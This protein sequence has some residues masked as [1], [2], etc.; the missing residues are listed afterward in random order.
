MIKLLAETPRDQEMIDKF[1]R[2]YN[3]LKKIVDRLQEE[4]RK[5]REELDEYRKRHP[6]NVGVKNGKT[7]DIRQENASTETESTG[8]RK[9]GAQP[10][11]IGHFRKT[12]AATERIFLKAKRF[13]C[14]VCHS[15]LQKN[16][17][18]GR[19]IEDIPEI[20]PRVVEYEIERMICRTC[21]NIYEPDV[22]EAF[23]GARISVRAMLIVAYFRTAMRMSIENV[24]N[25][26]R[27]I[28]GLSVSEG[29][30]QNILSELS[31]SLDER[32]ENLLLEVR[33]APSRN[34]DSTSSR[35]SGENYNLWVFVT[36]GEAI[37]HTSKSNSHDVP[38][39]VLGKH[40]GTDVHDRHSAFETLA[41]KTGNDQQYCWS[42]VIDDAKELEQF[43]GEEGGRIK[44]SLRRIYREGLSFHGHGTMEDVDRLHEKLIFLIDSDYD[45]KKCRN[46]VD[47]LLKRKKEWLFKFVMD[48]HVEGTNNR[49]ERALRPFVI[50]RK[51]SGGFRSHA[52]A[53]A[54]DIIF[55]QYYTSKLRK[56]NFI[57]D[58]PAVMTRRRNP[59]PG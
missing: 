6:A 15:R 41:R 31:E 43:Y 37:F 32:Y 29:E 52:G 20:K 56:E 45:H 24:S 23:P 47:N 30:I 54:H 42:H 19:K 50:Y 40:E 1:Q 36:K 3:N 13:R 38:L 10:G 49:A 55:S 5:L 46:F 58:T 12:P 48:P 7:Y 34:M 22:A 18:T 27:E 25:T 28:F 2:A 9:P 14:P 11:H 17:T 21:G 44:R 35:I 39:T 53:R 57:R 4:N 33:N 8:K 51:V 26:I 16:G 59:K